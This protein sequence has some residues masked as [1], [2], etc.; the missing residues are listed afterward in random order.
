MPKLPLKMM[1]LVIF[2]T[3]R[4]FVIGPKVS[5]S[6]RARLE[7]RRW[8]SSKKRVVFLGSP[9]P[10]AKTLDR[11]L[12]ASRRDD[13]SFEVVGCV[14]QPPAAKGRKRLVQPCEVQVLAEE[15]GLTMMTPLK[16]KCPDFLE[17]LTALEP[18]LCITAAFGQFLPSD[19]L[20]IPA[21]GTWNIHPSLLPRYRGAAPLQRSL[22]A[23]DSVIGVTVLQT[24]LKMD[25]GPIVAQLERQ[26]RDDDDA[27]L[28]L[29][30]LF[31]AGLDLLLSQLPELWAGTITYTEQDEAEV[32][33]AP[34]LDV[35]EAELDLE[36]PPNDHRTIAKRAADKVRAF[37]PWPGTWLGIKRPDEEEASRLKVFI[38]RPAPDDDQDDRP[39]GRAISLVR[40][41]LRISCADGS[42][43][44]V[45]SVQPPNRKP[46][47]AKAFWCAPY[48]LFA[49]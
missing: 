11:L 46:M 17:Q 10:A 19:F 31:L 3:S 30:E 37:S 20:S 23:G 35:T 1:A 48:P 26:V 18:D 9:A 15:R 28:L 5:S 36:T 33:Q 45:T 25:A 14:S 22:E 32:S 4:A 44:D 21:Y 38:A 24:V 7:S 16:A 8:L 29:E 13:S 2:R 6:S 40:G 41:A 34:K 42:L 49:S 27:Q 39:R 12:D 47:D 43:L